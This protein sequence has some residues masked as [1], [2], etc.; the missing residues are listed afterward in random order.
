MAFIENNLLSLILL[1]PSVA[2]LGILFIPK[3]EDRVVK[4]SALILSL[5]PLVLSIFLWVNFE[6][7]LA[8]FQFEVQADW[9]GAINSSYHLGVDG[10]SMTM[11][12]LTTILTPIAILASFSIDDRIKSYMMLF[13]FLETGM[14]GVFLALDLLLFFVFWEIGLVPMYFLISQWGSEKGEREIWGGRKV[15]ARAYASVKFHDLHH[16]GLSR[17]SAGDPD[18][19][20]SLRDL[21]PGGTFPDLVFCAGDLVRRSGERAQ[22]R[23]VLGLCDRFCHQGADLAIPHL[24]A[25]CAH[26]SA[27]GRLHDPGRR[28]A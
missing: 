11:V 1:F 13:L 16:G 22:G 10:L 9:Y 19:R 4:W 28:A 7:T 27:Y 2:A 14:L 6:P 5:V 17:A 24:A 12:L 26:R 21:R 25:R 15:S 23:C 8:G 18:D 20:S 3:G